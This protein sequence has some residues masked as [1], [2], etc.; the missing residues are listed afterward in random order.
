MPKGLKYTSS[1]I[2][3]SHNIQESGANTFTQDTIDLQ[4]NPLDNEV[5]VVLAIDLDPSSPEVDAGGGGSGTNLSCSITSR[6]TVG[7]IG[8]TNVLGAATKRIQGALVPFSSMSPDGPQSAGLDYI[9]IVATS[10]IFVQIE[11]NNN[12]NARDGR[13][14][15]WCQRARADSSTYAALV[16]SEMLSQ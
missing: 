12:T 13:V 8:D 2:V 14:R 11:G 7:N 10:D 5:L 15:L 3:I 1:P 6:T 4:L 9:G 16:Q